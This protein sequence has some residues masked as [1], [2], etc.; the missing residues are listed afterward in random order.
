MVSA[1]KF[2]VHCHMGGKNQ[3]KFSRREKQEFFFFFFD[4]TLPF[5]AKNVVLKGHIEIRRHLKAY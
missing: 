2:L 1:F 3:I 5:Y 4:K